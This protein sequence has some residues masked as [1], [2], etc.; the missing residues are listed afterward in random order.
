[1]A[2]KAAGRVCMAEARRL[3]KEVADPQKRCPYRVLANTASP[4]SLPICG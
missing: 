3:R 4:Q 1:M 2:Q